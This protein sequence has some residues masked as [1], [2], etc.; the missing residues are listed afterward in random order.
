[1]HGYKFDLSS[2]AA[3]NSNN[4]APR[5][6]PITDGEVFTH[7]DNPVVEIAGGEEYVC[8]GDDGG[9]IFCYSVSGDGGLKKICDF[10]NPSSVLSSVCVRGATLLSSYTSGEIRIHNLRTQTIYCKISGHSRAITAMD[11]YPESDNNLF[12]MWTRASENEE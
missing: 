7:H 9:R 3:C 8:S 11:V 4:S 12:C 2:D 6:D 5:S 10:K 1:M